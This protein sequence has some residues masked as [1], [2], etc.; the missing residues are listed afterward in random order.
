MPDGVRL[1][2]GA[3]LPVALSLVAT[4]CFRASG[5]QRT[6][7]A[8]EA[9]PE[10]GGDR[11]TGLKAAA[12]PGDYY[13][14]NDFIQVTVDG[15]RFGDT[16][17]IPI[18]GAQGG[19]S[20][21]DAGYLSLDTSY[22]RVNMPADNL[23]RLTPVLNQDPDIQIVIDTYT[24]DT[25]T[26][27]ATLTMTGGVVDKSHKL[28]G[29][30]WDASG[31]VKG[32]TVKH[33]LS[34][35]KLDR[36]FTLSTTVTNTGSARI[37]VRNIGDNLIQTGGG[38]FQLAIPAGIDIFGRPLGDAKRWGVEIPG[39]DFGS[40]IATSVQAP[41]ALMVATEPGATVMDSHAS[42]GI[43]PLDAPSL[44]VAAD[45]QTR[46]NAVRP[47][48]PR[49]MVAG[50][51]PLAPE[52]LAAGASLTH[53]RRLYIAGGPS[54]STT[55]PST[56]TGLFN[57]IAVAKYNK[58]DGIWPQDAANLTFTLSGSAVR[59]GPLPTEVRVERNAGSETSPLWVPERIEWLESDENITS[60]TGLA[61]STVSCILPL[62][63]YRLVVRNALGEQTKATA[64]NQNDSGGSLI[65]R[66]IRLSTNQ[67]FVVGGSDYLCP[68]A[69]EVVSPNGT[70]VGSKY[71]GHTFTTRQAN[72]PTAS[73]QPL[74]LTFKGTGDTADPWMRRSRV[75]GTYYEPI[76]K[77]A[78]I[79]SINAPGQDQYRGGNEMFGTGFHN[80][81][82]T[83]YFWLPNGT[84][85]GGMTQEGNPAVQGGAYRV[86]GT[87]GPLSNLASLDVLA[88]DGQ[89]DTSHTVLVWPTTLPSG[90]T[91]FDL[92]G[93]SQATTGGYL[94]GEKLASALA[95]G[96]GVVATTEED[97]ATDANRLYNDFKWQFNAAGY[98]A[99]YLAAVGN[100][101]YVVG[102]R[103]SVLP[104]W[105]TF[106]AL[107]TPT[108]TRYRYQGAVQPRNWS[109]ADF[110][111]QAQGSFTIVHQPRA[112]SGLF[113]LKGF[114]RAMPVG[115]GAN[116]W[117]TAS[118]PYAQGV[119][120][121]A[122][123]AIELLRGEGFDKANP[124]PW[125]QQF[126][127]VRADW[128]ALLNQQ[129][130]AK[131]TKAL[132]LSYGKYSVDTPV[133]LARTWLKATP[134]LVVP[135]T[136]TEAPTKDLEQ[137]LSS[138][139]SALKA[140]AAVAST[141]PMLD[142]TIGSKGPGGLVP[143]PVT[144]A[145]VKVDL[146]KSDWMPVDEVRIVM[147]GQVVGTH[148]LPEFAADA[149]NPLHFTATFSVPMPTTGTGAW[150]VVEAGVP[151]GQTGPY[152]AG[153]PWNW[154]MRGI[155]PI[156]VT[157]PIFI[158][159]TGSGY[160]HP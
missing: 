27:P 47:I 135:P 79:P 37:G 84:L 145:S 141:G 95:E 121:G 133:G 87:R 68:E 28:A 39:S 103:T 1:G 71:S 102:A 94:P 134:S 48:F 140:G 148:T 100:E 97:L 43:M 107:F 32:L 63:T 119:L 146:Y 24:P 64:A 77:A 26:D 78:A 36:F 56:T 34:L 151:L 113:T 5:L 10:N 59:Q 20:I 75:L 52:G 66:P 158:D 157:N 69:D 136:P 124:D 101:P 92:P 2:L 7:V 129:T 12:G 55:T 109:L 115:Q 159:V 138:V 29:A 91:S 54:G 110:I 23:E 31:R 147:N 51:L 111:T 22:Q 130:P 86:Y 88:Y 53:N 74:R 6:T 33:V 46:L 15:T 72:A 112:A 93:P 18:A 61:S 131:F 143:G 122:F 89:Y 120:N 116:A 45:P 118:G 67:I 65:S 144:T 105:G 19:G 81:A 9:M 85:T 25:H 16:A 154:I 126:K 4:G 14:G 127:Q 160:T 49:R 82:Q 41:S 38:G 44:A 50:S 83:T 104:G 137:D 106:T 58:D 70:V 128:F 11:V 57:L 98:E 80:Y 123:D 142:V 125:F 149:A 114:D 117:W 8:A 62:G 40:P 96:V 17:Q 155:Y 13:L 132:G 156:A 99:Q 152:A 60:Q 90:W 3:V 42:L 153:T 76:L 35:G 150:I 108:A 139:L 30:S 21:V 73:I